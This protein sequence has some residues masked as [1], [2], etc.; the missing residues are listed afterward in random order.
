MMTIISVV[1]P[2]EPR[3]ITVLAGILRHAS[4]GILLADL[5][6][7]S[8]RTASKN[9][10]IERR[11]INIFGENERK[12]DLDSLLSFVVCLMFFFYGGAVIF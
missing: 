5:S 3:T 2:P 11:K 1:W 10:E 6:R 12:L 4:D 7:Y 9:A 8:R